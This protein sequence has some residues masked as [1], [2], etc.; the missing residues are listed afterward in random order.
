M[1]EPTPPFH[2]YHRDEARMG[3]V[4]TDSKGREWILPDDARLLGC[5]KLQRVA[6]LRYVDDKC[7]QF[8]V[9]EHESV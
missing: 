7:E 3:E 1:M 5:S 9:G 2:G 4:C 8:F 6:R